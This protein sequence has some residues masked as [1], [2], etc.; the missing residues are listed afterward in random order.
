MQKKASKFV[1]FYLHILARVGTTPAP[2]HAHEDGEERRDLERHGPRVVAA[3][4]PSGVG[5]AQPSAGRSVRAAAAR[6]PRPRTPRPRVPA[7][8]AKATS[9]MSALRRR[10]SSSSMAC[11]R[12]RALH[13]PAP[14]PTAR[15]SPATPPRPRIR[16]RHHH[17]HARRARVAAVAPRWPQTP[18]PGTGALRH[19]HLLHERPAAALV[20]VLRGLPPP[21]H[22]PRPDPGPRLRRRHRRGLGPTAVGGGG[23]C[24]QQQ[25][26]AAS[27]QPRTLLPGASALREHPAVPHVLILRGLP[28]PLRPPSPIP[29]IST[30]EPAPQLLLVSHHERSMQRVKVRISDLRGRR[31]TVDARAGVVGG[32]G[33]RVSRRIERGERDEEDVIIE[34]NK[35]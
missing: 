9:S 29:G 3:Q 13:A 12:H 30:A 31:A 22:P 32:S 35:I 34:D 16:R 28:L 23:G 18:P 2:H 6:P 11:R 19:G 27:P 15:P 25:P 21:P 14:T 24:E 10:M 7:S 1:I 17:R 4:L 8:S 26:V 20:L 5:P 33:S